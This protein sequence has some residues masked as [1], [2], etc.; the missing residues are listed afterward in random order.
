MIIS[1]S[2]DP[3][4][5]KYKVLRHQQLTAMGFAY[6]HIWKPRH[7]W[8][9]RFLQEPLMRFFNKWRNMPTTTNFFHFCVS[10]RLGER[11][12]KLK[13]KDMQIGPEPKDLIREAELQ[14]LLRSLACDISLFVDIGAN[15]GVF[16]ICL[17]TE[18]RFQGK[19]MA[20]EPFP[21]SFRNLVTICSAVDPEGVITPIE[22]ALSDIDGEA[23]MILSVDS[24]SG[25]AKITNEDGFSIR[26]QRLD[27]FNV[28]PSFL[29]IDVEGHESKVL[30]GARETISR[31]RPYIY[32]ENRDDASHLEHDDINQFFKDLNYA[33]FIPAWIYKKNDLWSTCR[34][35]VPKQKNHLV[36]IDISQHPS[37]LYNRELLLSLNLFACP[38]EKIDSLVNRIS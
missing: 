18:Q 19:I 10:H 8:Q 14:F 32:F 11:S 22:I 28:M 23:K 21:A 3:F 30:H 25:Y 35:P 15:A 9:R 5:A 20:F 33:I 4:S 27:N 2:V 38:R 31:S 7:G 29:K 17:L 6:K 13:S 34:Q 36:L 12:F 1:R 16:S 24:H 26:T 37:I